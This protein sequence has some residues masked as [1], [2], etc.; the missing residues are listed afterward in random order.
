MNNT[1]TVYVNGKVLYSASPKRF[2]MAGSDGAY[3]PCIYFPNNNASVKGTVNF[4]KYRLSYLPDGYMNMNTAASRRDFTTSI[5]GNVIVLRDGLI[6]SKSLYS[7]LRIESIKG[8]G[9]TKLEKSS[10]VDPSVIKED[11]V[12]F[13]IPEDGDWLA[14]NLPIPY[15]QKIYIE[16]MPK[17]GI[18][19]TDYRGIP[20]SFP[21][22]RI[23]V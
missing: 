20:V 7:N 3:Y 21:S 10:I 18:V 17:N 11:G 8:D 1:I 16:L 4:G 15:E 13:S 23:Y 5:R 6:C 22:F 9:T 12:S 19:R 14:V 2:T